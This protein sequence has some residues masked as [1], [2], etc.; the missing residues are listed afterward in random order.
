MALRTNLGRWLQNLYVNA[1]G[2]GLEVR[3]AALTN[4]ILAIENGTQSICINEWT[5]TRTKINDSTTVTGS[6]NS[7]GLLYNGN[8][9]DSTYLNNVSLNN[10]APPNNTYK[11]NYDSV[12]NLHSI[13]SGFG[14]IRVYTANGVF[15]TYTQE[16]FFNAFD[17]YLIFDYSLLSENLGDNSKY[18]SILGF[19]NDTI[20]TGNDPVALRYTYNNDT[21]TVPFFMRSQNNVDTTVAGS[22]G[23]VISPIY[24]Y[25]ISKST[26]ANYYPRPNIFTTQNL[27]MLYIYAAELLNAEGATI[28]YDESNIYTLRGTKIYNCTNSSGNKPFIIISKDVLDAFI[29]DFYNETGIYLTYT[30]NI[31]PPAINTSELTELNIATQ[32]SITPAFDSETLTYTIKVPIKE[33]NTYLLHLV[34]NEYTTYV[35][36][37]ID[38]RQWQGSIN[39]YIDANIEL[40][41]IGT[42]TILCKAEGPNAPTYTVTVNVYDPTQTAP[43]QDPNT[44]NNEGGTGEWT[45]E[46][47]DKPVTPGAGASF[48]SNTYVLTYTQLKSLSNMFFSD[49]AI[50]ALLTGASSADILSAFRGAMLWPFDFNDIDVPYTTTNYIKM[51]NL[52]VGDGTATFAEINALTTVNLDCGTLE[53]QERYG[54]F[55]DYPPYTKML[56]YLP[57]C[58][59][60]ELDP[61]DV[62]GH[63]VHLYYLVDIESGAGKACIDIDDIPMYEYPCQLAVPISFNANDMYEKTR[64]AV[65]GVVNSFT[66][67]STQGKIEVNK[68][69]EGKMQG[70]ETNPAGM[71]THIMGGLASTA[72][73]TAM[74]KTTYSSI[75]S[76]GNGVERQQPQYPYIITKS[77]QT[78]VPDNYNDL[79]G[80]PS[81]M[82][83]QLKTLTGFTSVINPQL[84]FNAT[85]EE[86]AEIKALL[87]KGVYL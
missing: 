52:S 67:A 58:G 30:G 12:S 72:I 53:L 19:N 29:V 48:F 51:G 4:Y 9:E 38:D 54:G 66:G 63:E 33:D 83:L 68:N 13:F 82:Y 69:E 17:N 73:N 14:N 56:I 64:N 22:K 75:G 41:G 81:L 5:G 50:S 55:L 80:R 15:T 1:T 18:G 61:A 40:E 11:L 24:M 36:Y 31:Q 77:V 7:N 39:P 49:N 21:V 65:M 84:E 20:V 23:Y 47:I 76:V 60:K 8:D 42:Y 43:G 74:T 10:D 16:N 37:K 32:T 78:S 87:E 86:K 44:I 26:A 6:G 35:S 46:S 45:I 71:I 27:N 59:F 3:R 28:D 57:Y 25:K 2:D 85:E 62:Y 70:I 34:G 79:A